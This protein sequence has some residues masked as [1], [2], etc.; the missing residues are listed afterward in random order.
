MYFCGV[1]DRFKLNINK[2][3]KKFRTQKLLL[4]ISGG[5]D[6]RVLLHLFSQC[7]LDFGV[8]HCNF[9]LRGEE[10]DADAKFVEEICIKNRIPFE[11]KKF[12][13]KAHSQKHKISTQM[14]ARELR[15]SWFEE[16]LENKNYDKI[17]TAHHLDDQLETFMINT[18]R[19][20][21]L[22]G[23]IGIPENTSTVARPMLPFTRKE[24]LEYAQAE[25]LVWRE[26]T[27]NTSDIYLR[28]A[29]R[30]QVVTKWKAY[31]P[32]LLSNFGDTLSYIKQSL[33]AL[34]VVVNQWEEQHFI[35]KGAHIH[36]D[37]KALKK[38]TP[39]EY[40]LHALFSTYGFHLNDL[41]DL[42]KAQS[43]KHLQSSSYRLLV[44][45]GEWILAEHNFLPIAE[46]SWNLTKPLDH[47]I[48]LEVSSLFINNNSCVALDQSLLILPLKLRKFQEGDY[49]YPTGM[50]GKKKLS[51]YFKDEKYSQIE[52]ENQWLLCSENSIVWVI[53]K[54]A[55]RRYTTKPTDNNCLIIKVK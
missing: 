25:N 32:N 16:L 37:L 11:I 41:K 36:I 44:N 9:G 24:I 8:A 42:L 43:G 50:Q 31:E 39:Q 1:I 46:I 7:K 34:D 5:L 35:H 15:Y 3:F 23:L 19:G 30:N 20:S 4:A 55:D 13:T 38:L 52:K 2:K 17:V 28:N 49:F 54:R 40:Y 10:S 6:S 22:S 21:G 29:L 48:K 26:D 53:G 47:P 12:E 27:S 18:G 45:R 14:A 33:Q 51:K